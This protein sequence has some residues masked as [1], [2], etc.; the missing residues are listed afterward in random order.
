[1]AAAAGVIDVDAAHAETVLAGVADA[2]PIVKAE[3]TSI[4]AWPET[5]DPGGMQVATDPVVISDVAATPVRHLLTGQ[6]A[7]RFDFKTE[8][9]ASR[10]LLLCDKNPIGV[11][12]PVG[13][14]RAMG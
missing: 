10:L 14:A 11:A 2:L 4:F 7:I 1:L 5:R 6:S 13:R 12:T 9:S 3:N 8:T